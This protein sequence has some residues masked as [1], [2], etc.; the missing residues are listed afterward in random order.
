MRTL[1]PVVLVAALPVLVL[2]AVP[3]LA[4]LAVVAPP[5]HDA[6]PL[7]ALRALGVL[8]TLAALVV[9]L[10]RVLG[11]SSWGTSSGAAQA[12]SSSCL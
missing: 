11:L 5:L 7:R 10:V 8:G 12:V 3:V 2:V 6:V 1:I 9:H 4:D